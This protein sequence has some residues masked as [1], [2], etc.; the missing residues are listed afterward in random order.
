MFFQLNEIWMF[1]KLNLFNKY[2]FWSFTLVFCFVFAWALLSSW[3]C[4]KMQV[5]KT[6][7]S[8]SLNKFDFI[9]FKKFHRVRSHQTLRIN[10]SGRSWNSIIDNFC[11]FAI[12][13][14]YTCYVPYTS[15]L[16]TKYLLN[17]FVFEN[18]KSNMS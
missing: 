14:R 5:N 12:F 11:R 3:S 2:L 15:I 16:Y 8:N 6:K 1:F 4:K 18:K 7:T 13:L 17:S 10:S 9:N